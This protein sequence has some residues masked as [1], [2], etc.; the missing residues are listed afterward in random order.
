MCKY[1]AMMVCIFVLILVNCQ[2]GENIQLF[3]C[4]EIGK[5]AIR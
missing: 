5:M 3:H 1:D 4:H 2:A